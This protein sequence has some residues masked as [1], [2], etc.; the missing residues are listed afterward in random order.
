MYVAFPT[1]NTYRHL[2]HAVHSSAHISAISANEAIDSDYALSDGKS[3]CMDKP[4]KRH[5]FLALRFDS[6]FSPV[7]ALLLI[8][9]LNNL[10]RFIK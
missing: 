4:L 7:K 9:Q 8:H 2:K 6:G 3:Y 5:R 10:R 1:C